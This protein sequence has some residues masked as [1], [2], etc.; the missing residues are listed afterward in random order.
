MSDAHLHSLILATSQHGDAALRVAIDDK[1]A[2]AHVI[3]NAGSVTGAA[4]SVVLGQ[5]ARTLSPLLQRSGASTVINRHA[6]EGLASYWRAGIQSLSG[7]VDAVLI[8]YG[9]QAGVSTSDLRRLVTAWNGAD[10]VIAT[11]IHGGQIATPT[12]IPRCFFTDLTHLRGDQSV[13]MV[14]QRH[15]SRIKPVIMPSAGYNP[16]DEQDLATIKSGIRADQK[17]VLL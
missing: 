11:A 16:V 6:A 3:R 7:S 4:I 13:R 8:L 12:I 10:S 17:E 5:D 9:D 1:P 14:V 15:A 2:L